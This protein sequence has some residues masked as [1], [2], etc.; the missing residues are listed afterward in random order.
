MIAW[1]KLQ[2]L[3]GR[4]A[5]ERDMADEMR[6]HVEMEAAELVRR[7]M[8]PDEAERI[9]RATFG[10]IERH[11]DDARDAIGIRLLDDLAQDLRYAA[12]QLRA[13]PGFTA[14]TILTLALGVGATTT[15]YAIDRAVIVRDVAFSRPDELVH[16]AVIRTRGEPLELGPAL[17]KVVRDFDR[18]LAVT[19]VETMETVID[20]DVAPDRLISAMMIGSAAAAVLIAAIGLY[21]VISY[22]VTQRV[23][24]FGIR[25]ALGAEPGAVVSLV[26]GQGL[27]LAALGTGLGI[28]GALATRRLLGSVLYG[29]SPDDPLTLLAVVVAM[30]GVGLAASYVPAR[31]A[32][33]ADPMQ[34]LREE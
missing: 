4:S 28:V 7:G 18:D 8:A 14:A 30:C 27:K 10:G 3:R 13:S 6:F 9:A 1:R 33:L 21:G 29:V 24:E 34:S 22:G 17:T 15:M 20:E 12:R 16:L 32:S 25:R 2:S 5:R 11:K 19:R 23:R 31:R 26:L